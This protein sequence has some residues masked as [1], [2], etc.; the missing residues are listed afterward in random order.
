MMKRLE[1]AVDP[2]MDKE[3]PAKRLA[4]VEITLKNG[5]VYRSDV[6]EAA[7]EPDDPALSLDWVEKKFKRITAPMLSSQDQEKLLA[8]MTT[9]LNVPVRNVVAQINRSLKKYV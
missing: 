1:F 2:K 9:G 5:T 7:G 8:V 3:F 4:W 6:Y